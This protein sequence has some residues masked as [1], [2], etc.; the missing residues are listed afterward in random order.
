MT[1]IIGKDG[2]IGSTLNLP[3]SDF[4]VL[5]A[6]HS[7]VK[8]AENDPGGAWINN[9]DFFR[10]QLKD[11]LI[12]ASSASVYDG[13][14]HPDEETNE[15]NLK[16]MYDL[17]K[18]TIDNLALSSDKEVYGLRF[19]TVNGWSPNLRVDIMLNK[20]V[21][22]ALTKGEVVVTNPQLV[23]PILGINDLGRAITAIIEDGRDKRGI[24]NLA[25][26]NASVIDM[27]DYVGAVTKARVV[28]LN[29]PSNETPYVFGLNTDKFKRRYSFTFQ[30]TLESVVESL[31]R[32]FERVGIRE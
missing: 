32:P 29:Q 9:V 3:E 15:F 26:F 8:M 27:A 23:R 13:V 22:D 7:S 16:G 4:T 2:Y 12:Y 24:Y 14:D 25:S 20:M 31:L 6:G 5:L 10:S 21:Y 17:T 18:R 19:A 30:D 28:I 11:K 1:R